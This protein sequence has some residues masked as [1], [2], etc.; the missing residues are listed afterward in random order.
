MKRKKLALRIGLCMLALGGAVGAVLVY[1]G[2]W[3]L[4]HPSATRYPV[5]GVD[6]S[7]YQ[8]YIDW[9]VLAAEDLCFAFV[10]ATEGSGHIDPY[11]A[12]NH[13]GALE[14]GLRVGA[15]H[16]FSYD[17]SGFTQAQNF[18]QA[19]PVTD[20]M[21][22]P[23]VDLEFYGDYGRNPM[24]AADVRQI[25]TPLLNELEL[26]YG[27][28]PILYVT[29]TSYKLYVQGYYDDYDIWIRSILG[30]PRLAGTDDWVFWQYTSRGKLEGYSGPERFIDINV[31]RGS[32]E[33]FQQ[34]AH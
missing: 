25:L 30:S 27:T 19:V 4:N 5:R 2:I 24:D 8:G 31:F 16:F 15:Y 17:S 3:Q 29:R 28:K 34:Y 7:S 33:E 11:F 9:E 12:Q 26:H 23:V 10:K 21:L 14:A 1:R 18:I 13:A 6:V 32:F 22:P 20:D